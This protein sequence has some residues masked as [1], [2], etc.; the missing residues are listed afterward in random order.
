MCRYGCRWMTI[1]GGIISGLGFMLSSFCDSIEMMYL[2]FGV[3]AGLGLG[4]CYVT[5]V[6]SIAYWFDKK[7]TLAT[8]LGACGTGVGT[9][10]YAPM[11]KYFIEEYG[12]RGTTL[13]LA[14]TFFNM[15]VCGAV[16]RDPEWWTL[17]QAKSN[18]GSLAGTK[19]VRAA[20]SCG[21]ISGRSEGGNTDFP[22]VEE[23]RRLLK[24][25]RTP[26]YILTALATY[27]G[28]E[29][30]VDQEEEVP[31]GAK[32]PAYSSVVNL[33]TF[34]RQSETVSFQFFFIKTLNSPFN[35]K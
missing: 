28:E 2:T 16:M 4:L 11:T 23:I 27:T 26:E 21:S 9:F 5:A 8:G 14:G 35:Y 12:W 6:V 33:P 10:L 25:G 3:I 31:D 19:S 1:T 13:L 30:K 15:C 17:E 7:R 34:I 22:G 18:A 29:A 32:T 20:S 24:S